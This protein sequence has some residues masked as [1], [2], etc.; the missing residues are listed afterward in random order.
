MSDRVQF[1]VPCPP[2]G[3]GPNGRLHWR[4]RSVMKLEYMLDVMPIVNAACNG[5][6]P[7]EQAHVLYEWH[8]THQVDADNAIGRLKPLLDC[9]EG[10]VIRNDRNVT[11]SYRWVKAKTKKQEEVIVTVEA[12]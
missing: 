2:G 12:R 11:L 6:T 1:S 10:R 9:L 7:F 8:S 4:K 5:L 3:L